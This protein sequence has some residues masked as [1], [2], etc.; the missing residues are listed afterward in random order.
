MY[1]GGR[2]LDFGPLETLQSRK[3]NLKCFRQRVYFHFSLE[4][5]SRLYALFMNV[6]DLWF[7]FFFPFFPKFRYITSSFEKIDY[8]SL[9]LLVCFESCNVW[10]F[11]VPCFCVRHENFN[12]QFQL[13]QIITFHPNASI[14]QNYDSMIFEFWHSFLY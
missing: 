11:N 6:T 1:P 7:S 3:V 8:L 12:F 5:E 10:L 9:C 4:L 2:D 13:V 14:F